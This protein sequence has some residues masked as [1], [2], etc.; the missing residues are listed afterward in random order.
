[1]TLERLRSFV[2]KHRGENLPTVAKNTT[3]KVNE[4]GRAFVFELT[5]G[6]TRNES[7]EWMKTSLEIFNRTGSLKGKDYPHSQNASYL[8]FHRSQLFLRDESALPNE[9][10][11][12][13]IHLT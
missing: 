11:L 3:F 5:S 9:A 7:F 8:A 4:K 12:D 6:K 2:A 1:M 10:A 13:P